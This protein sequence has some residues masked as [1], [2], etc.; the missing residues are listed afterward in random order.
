LATI[1]RPAKNLEKKER[2]ILVNKIVRRF[3]AQKKDG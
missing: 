2:Q 3:F 1:F